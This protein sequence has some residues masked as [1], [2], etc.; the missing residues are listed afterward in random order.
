MFEN[1]KKDKTMKIQEFIKSIA[2]KVQESANIKKIYGDP[3]EVQ[4]KTIIPVAR[5]AY[6]F[7][8]G[9]G[10]FNEL[11]KGKTEKEKM[12][13]VG[14]GCGCGGGVY[15]QPIGYIEVTQNKT[16]FVSIGIFKR[17]I[18]FLLLAFFLGLALGKL[19]DTCC[20]SKR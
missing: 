12:P 19:G 5:I 1:I 7:G 10:E 20:K 17:C 9:G 15:T 18:K 3:I 11:E 16:K 13:G 6:G 2:D 4:G 14:E 8:G